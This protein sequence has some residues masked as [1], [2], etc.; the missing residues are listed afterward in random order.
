[1]SMKCFFCGKTVYPAEKVTHDGKIFHNFCFTKYNKKMQ[2]EDKFVKQAE[3]YKN[4][5]VKPSY[6]RVA[7]VDNGQGARMS[8]STQDEISNRDKLIEQERREAEKLGIKNLPVNP[9]AQ[10]EPKPVEQPKP[11]PVQQPQPVEQP[12]CECAKETPKFCSQCGSKLEVGA[13]FCSQC[14]HKIN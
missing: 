1:M 5:D 2:L 4:P 6:Y 14:G 13:R 10:V 9:D 8:T 3:Y 7:D 11:A 12:K